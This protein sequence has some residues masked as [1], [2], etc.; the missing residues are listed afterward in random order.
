MRNYYEVTLHICD[1]GAR[2][3][4]GECG[5]VKKDIVLESGAFPFKDVLFDR[6]QREGHEAV[7]SAINALRKSYQADQRAKM[8]KE[9]K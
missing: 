5:K 1:N 2:V 6:L 4:H 3:Y 7:E 9:S 8:E